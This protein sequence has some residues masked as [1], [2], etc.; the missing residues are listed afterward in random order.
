MSPPKRRGRPRPDDDE[1]CAAAGRPA[2]AAAAAAAASRP[3]SPPAA[4]KHEK[5]D[6]LLSYRPPAAQLA[7]L[8]AWLPGAGVVIN[9]DAIV[10]TS[11]PAGGVAVH[12]AADLAPGTLLATIPKTAV[13]SCRS[14]AVAPA[15]ASA[16][17]AGG[18]AVAVAVAAE[19][20]AGPAS[21]WAGYLTSLPRPAENLP[22][23]WP[24]SALAAAAGSDLPGRAAGDAA[25]VEEDF[26]E[27][28]LPLVP[29]IVACLVDAYGGKE[30]SLLPPKPTLTARLSSLPLFMAATTW[31]ASRSFGVD[32][33]HG[34]GMVP[35]ADAFNHKAAIVDLGGGGAWAVERV[36]FAD[37]EDEDEEGEEGI[38]ASGS[39]SEGEGGGESESDNDGSPSLA[40]EEEDGREVSGSG[41]ESETDEG[42]PPPASDDDWASLAVPLRPDGLHLEL[43][44]C[45]STDATTGSPVLECRAASSLK[46]GAEVHNTYG[47]HGAAD[48]AA[49]Y[50]FALPSPVPGPFDAVSLRVGD[51]LAAAETLH[52][53]RGVRA[54]ARFLGETDLL[55]GGGEPLEVCA[56]GVVGAGLRVVLRVLGATDGEL[57]GWVGLEDATRPCGGGDG[58]GPPAPLGAVALAGG[59]TGAA[60]PPVTAGAAAVLAAAVAARLREYPAGDCD[61]DVAA[62]SAAVD[63]AAAALARRPCAAA[64]AAL[65]AARAVLTARVVVRAEQAV[66]RQAAEAVEELMEG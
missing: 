55:D 58:S 32:A 1:D 27:H 33:V 31:V 48:L 20:A 56:G 21:P 11:S 34:R 2:K 39:G 52:G 19:A 17:L 13:L 47:E 30:S 50:G 65:R 8:T 38:E 12:A 29:D 45:G 18:L 28:V 24:A 54:R 22:V 4:A 5:E 3:T 14:T 42:S 43:A 35:L 63:A 40:E 41:S 46:A 15:L 57:D 37:S 64:G 26:V 6:D 9:T 16:H 53:G 66:L 44:I 10:L 49:R 51:L 60:D 62:A 59:G 36:C 61:A 7:A 25:A 23:A